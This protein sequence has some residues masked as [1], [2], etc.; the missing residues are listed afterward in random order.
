MITSYLIMLLIT[1]ILCT[2]TYSLAIMKISK[3]RCRAYIFRYKQGC[4]INLCDYEIFKKCCRASIFRYKQ[5]CP[6]NLCDYENFKKCCRESRFLKFF[7]FSHIIK[8]WNKN[9]NLKISTTFFEN[10]IIAKIFSMF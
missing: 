8:F 5:G 10:F 9:L 3:K 6:I 4:P 7:R 2:Y 1:D